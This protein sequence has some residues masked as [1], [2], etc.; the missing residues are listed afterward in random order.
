MNRHQ[1][2][3]ANAKCEHQQQHTDQGLGDLAFQNAARCEIQCPGKRICPDHRRQ[4][5]ADGRAQQYPHIDACRLYSRFIALVGHQRVSRNGQHF[6]EYEQCEQVGG[7]RDPHR[8][9]QGNSEANIEPGLVLLIVAAHIADRIY[10]VY[11]P[12]PRC[13]SS[14]QHTDRFD[15]EGDFEARQHF[16]KMQL[17]A[18]AC[19]QRGDQA[20]YNAGQGNR[21]CQRYGFAHIGPAAGQR[22]SKG[23]DK[24]YRQRVENGVGFA[25]H[26]GATPSKVLAA[27]EA[28]PTGRD[29]STANHT[30]VSTTTHVGISMARGASCVTGTALARGSRK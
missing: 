5:Q 14:K 28:R 10:R 2:S 17:R 29:E 9:K 16:N 27:V 20:P 22:N 25:E 30:P 3:L 26:H 6:V 18:P 15:L 1:G 12:E 24:R 19:L 4:E 7:K 21:S 13:K 8:S 11:D 23:A